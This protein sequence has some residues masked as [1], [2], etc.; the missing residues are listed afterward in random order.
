MGSVVSDAV[1]SLPARGPLRSAA[2]LR[3]SG[4]EERIMSVSP[5]RPLAIRRQHRA[6]LPPDPPAAAETREDRTS[7][8]QDERGSPFPSCGMPMPQRSSLAE[9]QSEAG[10]RRTKTHV[11]YG[12]QPNLWSGNFSEIFLT[13][14]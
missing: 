14:L 7:T 10:R 2:K 1:D 3:R 6:A 8:R 4:G 11:Y 12:P 5:A 9:C 13:R